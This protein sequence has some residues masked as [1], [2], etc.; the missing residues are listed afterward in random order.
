MDSDT[1]RT[2]FP[3]IMSFCIIILLAYFFVIPTGDVPSTNN[4]KPRMEPV[5]EKKVELP[6][7]P[8]MD[9]LRKDAC[10]GKR[11]YDPTY[12]NLLKD[13]TQ[14]LKRLILLSDST[15]YEDALEVAWMRNK[16]DAQLRGADSDRMG[17][18]ISIAVG[19]TLS[20]RHVNGT[21]R[22]RVI[23]GISRLRV[24]FEDGGLVDI[25]M[26]KY[27]PII[28]QGHNYSYHDYNTLTVCQGGRTHYV[29]VFWEVPTVEL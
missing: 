7:V 27:T 20:I 6:V 13:T 15:A 2:L 16:M 29:L 24:R 3:L 25:S 8:P 9:A 12:F 4:I 22:N 28:H 1:K 17:D 10:E 21:I 23:A 11:V 26:I 5:K 18:Q 14:Q 19:S